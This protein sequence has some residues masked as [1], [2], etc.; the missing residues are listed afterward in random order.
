V[1]RAA[2]EHATHAAV[3]VTVPPAEPVVREHRARLD[4]SAAWGV[5]AHLTVLYPFVEP[6]AIVDE[7]CARLAAA[8]ASVAP[9]DCTFRGCGWFDQD[10]LWLAPEP[11]G[12][13][14]ALTTSVWRAFPDH[15]PYGGEYDDLAP[16]LTVA[17]RGPG[18]VAELRDIEVAVTLGLPITTRVDRVTLISGS[19]EPNSWRTVAEFALG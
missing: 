13:F 1:D 4:P 10:V 16:H 18:G 12:P 9:F 5:P 3:V 14:Q 19:Q 15:A 11:V 2:L 17:Q 6:S 8:V 7:V